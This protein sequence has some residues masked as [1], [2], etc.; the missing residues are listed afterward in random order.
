MQLIEFTVKP[1]NIS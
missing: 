1:S